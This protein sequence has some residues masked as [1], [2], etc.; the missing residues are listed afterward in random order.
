MGHYRDGIWISDDPMQ[1][2]NDPF[3]AEE[4]RKRSASVYEELTECR[5]RLSESERFIVSLS[6]A[7]RLARMT[8]FMRPD[9]P[10]PDHLTIETMR[11][12]RRDYEAFQAVEKLLRDRNKSEIKQ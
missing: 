11:I 4:A 12:A 5:K 9:E 10:P 3:F 7:L 1:Q 8:K 6:E 2:P